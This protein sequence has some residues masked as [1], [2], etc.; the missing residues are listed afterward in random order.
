[1]ANNT[2]PGTSNKPYNQDADTPFFG[3]TIA[4]GLAVGEGEGV[5]MLLAVGV[6]TP[7]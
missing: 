1:M 4:V 6:A 7:W 3:S 2:T 5:G